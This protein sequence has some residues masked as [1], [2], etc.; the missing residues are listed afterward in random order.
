MVLC[1]I[2]GCRWRKWQ[3]IGENYIMPSFMICILT[4]YFKGIKSRGVRQAQTVARMG[5]REMYTG[6]W[7]E[8][9]REETIWNA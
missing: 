4:K 3:E 1:K 6:L 2:F 5:G 9:L 7:W 8:N